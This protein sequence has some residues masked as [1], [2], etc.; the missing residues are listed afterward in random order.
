MYSSLVSNARRSLFTLKS[1]DL[2][3]LQIGTQF[4]KR[5]GAVGD[6]S[7]RKEPLNPASSN[8]SGGISCGLSGAPHNFPEEVVLSLWSHAGM[9]RGGC[10]WPPPPH[11]RAPHDSAARSSSW[12]GIHI[13][14]TDPRVP[15]TPDLL[16]KAN[17]YTRVCLPPTRF[18][19]FL[20]LF[21]KEPPPRR[22]LEA[23]AGSSPRPGAQARW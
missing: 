23:T 2:P 15:R 7:A 11:T 1:A 10:R 12:R 21:P 13:N 20:Y 17:Q 19:L 22:V 18:F 8:N 6:I 9:G 16:L 3:P 14:L 5:R 4:G